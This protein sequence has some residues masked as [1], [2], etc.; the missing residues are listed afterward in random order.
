MLKKTNGKISKILAL[1]LSILLLF[2][3]IPVFL[4]SADN[5]APEKYCFDFETDT[6]ISNM[7]FSKGSVQRYSPETSGYDSANVHGG[8]GSLEVS[9]V[10]GG[11]NLNFRFTG[12][13][14]KAGVS[15]KL[16]FYYKTNKSIWTYFQ[17]P[18]KFNVTLNSEDWAYYSRIITFTSDVSYL[19][20]GQTTSEG[21]SY[22]DDITLSPLF[23]ITA[24]TNDSALGSA[25]SS[26]KQAEAGESVTFTA[27]PTAD[28]EFVSWQDEGGNTVSTENPYNVAAVSGNIRLTA[29]FKNIN[30]AY[31]QID[32][33]TAA[34]V[35]NML[36]NAGTAELYQAT[37]EQDKNV[38]SG[39]GSLKISHNSNGGNLRLLLNGVSFDKNRKYQVVLNVYSEKN[40]WF[41]I[42]Y[43]NKYGFN[44]EPGNWKTITKDILFTEDKAYLEL[45]TTT[46]DAVSYIDNIEIREYL[47]VSA[48]SKDATLGNTNVS[49]NE[50]LYGSSVVF[51][52]TPAVGASFVEW[53]NAAGTTVSTENPYTV[54]GITGDTAL[55][56]VFAATMT[57]EKYL[58]FEID[59]PFSNMNLSKGTAERYI[60]QSE[61]D[62]NV[63]A[64]KASFKL[65]HNADKGILNVYFRNFKLKKDTT[66]RV[67]LWYKTN[68]KAWTFIVDGSKYSI[69]MIAGG[70]TKAEKVIKPTK[71]TDYLEFGTSQALS[72]IYLDNISVE[73][74]YNISATSSDEN[75][76]SATVSAKSAANGESV[77]FTAIPQNGCT[78]VGWK[79]ADSEQI[80]STQQV[81]TVSEITSDIALVA[82]F[83]GNPLPVA[84]Q[85]LDFEGAVDYSNMNFSTGEV[86]VYT[87]KNENDENVFAGSKSFY[88]KR[89]NNSGNLNFR[90]KNFK[91][92]AGSTYRVS[93]SYKVNDNAWMYIA[94]SSKYGI[95]LSSK[96]WA[97]IEKDITFKDNVNYLEFG[98]TTKS[99]VVYFDDIRVDAVYSTSAESA[100]STRG[101]AYAADSS[102][103]AGG[104]MTFTAL[105]KNGCRFVVWHTVSDDTIISTE[106]IYTVKNIY[107]DISLV[108]EF[109]GTPLPTPVQNINFE[110]NEK[111]RNRNA[112]C[113]EAFLYDS[114]AKNYNSANVYA[115]GGSLVLKHSNE[116][117]NLQV[118][119]DGAELY[120]GSIYEISFWY[121]TNT[122]AWFYCD[123]VKNN[124]WLKNT[125]WS[126]YTTRIV[127]ESNRNYLEIGVTTLGAEVYFDNITI[128]Y[129]ETFTLKA[130][131]ADSSLGTAK[132]SSAVAAKGDTVSFTASPI[133]GY[134]LSAWKDENGNVLSRSKTYIVSSVEGNMTLY[135]VF[136]KNG[137]PTGKQDFENPIQD[138]MDRGFIW[139]YE[140]ETGYNPN[141]VHNGKGSLKFVSNNSW[142]FYTADAS[143]SLEPNTAYEVVLW[144]KTESASDL[145]DRTVSFV[146]LKGIEDAGSRAYLKATGGEWQRVKAAFK[147]KDFATTVRLGMYQIATDLVTVYFDD[148]SVE[149]VNIYKEIP[150]V[151]TIDF[152]T[153]V[154]QTAYFTWN[155]DKRYTRN[156][157]V[158]SLKFDGSGMKEKHAGYT[159]P[160]LEVEPFTKYK[161]SI[162]VK[163]LKS[164]GFGKAQFYLSGAGAYTSIGSCMD[165][166]KEMSFT[167]TTGSI[168]SNVLNL[169]I[170]GYADDSFFVDDF[171]LT[172]I[173]SKGTYCEDLYN[174]IKNG[175][176]EKDITSGTIS[177]PSRGMAVTE[178]ISQSGTHS[179]EITEKSDALIV[180][181]QIKKAG[182]YIFAF[183]HKNTNS[184]PITVELLKNKNGTLV[185]TVRNGK[186]GKMNLG[187]AAEWNRES[188]TFDMPTA[189]NTV[190]LKISGSKSNVNLDDM[191][192]FEVR[193]A[194]EENPNDYTVYKPFDYDLKE[195][196]PTDIKKDTAPA[197]EK[198]NIKWIVIPCSVVVLAVIAGVSVVF[199]RRKKNAK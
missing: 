196:K 144:Y 94:D 122:D 173:E 169:Q 98:T 26:V 187:A 109:E 66:Y 160:D 16:S 25:E 163:G 42:A 139:N 50:A 34:D 31:Q 137:K 67:S 188:I 138:V 23:D 53:Q 7:N 88:A 110:K 155:T 180:P 21:I 24:G 150:T 121:K 37:D 55:T 86:G 18:N 6:K 85:I 1:S 12:L 161:A 90:F 99:A 167:F 125:E 32:F 2:Q 147:T 103:F 134:H 181:V 40:V 189:D 148:I 193:Y 79:Y 159:L 145:G 192:I 71:D 19:E 48:A 131:S 28:G 15:Y 165:E 115:G 172:K 146:D 129:K 64:G 156:S 95:T 151:Q 140:T 166:W 164:G 51:S 76:G 57:S 61:N 117:G 17:D 38:Y 45:G 127:P 13:S 83:T 174:L 11:G 92:M 68:I 123:N 27:V 60:A 136:E 185:D 39:N 175:S 179:L 183:S 177:A 4:L 46:K 77:T 142:Q 82:V 186:T 5:A 141:G 113:G 171:T 22:F 101:T 104:E 199:V 176:F 87:A 130:V 43:S 124:T 47:N 168:E 154:P 108:A 157:S 133:D 194:Y 56:A 63:Y 36:L 182:R 143:I 105:P 73:E 91:F 158:G 59:S 191:A 58:D 149:K 111:I 178:S 152:D 100:D 49:T 198:S 69:D 29:V 102:V 33:D 30:R 126:L 81:Y 41:Y 112:K 80:I 120:A 75:L 10:S 44:S 72:E 107:S 97:R 65:S 132:V 3:M 9:H 62:E 114:S 14:I 96:T 54:N 89:N 119:I 195:N 20:M 190:Y 184:E 135:A 52:A 197:K 8:T 128:T 70:W 170:I 84:T 78:F 35:T 153:K 118:F 93:F 162:W 116:K 74:V 106:A